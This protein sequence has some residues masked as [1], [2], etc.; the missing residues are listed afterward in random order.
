MLFE[1]SF[2]EIYEA[3]S[4]INEKRGKSR[5][6][7]LPQSSAESPT[8][9]RTTSLSGNF[10]FS[11]KRTGYGLTN[12]AFEDSINVVVNAL[13][14]VNGIT[15]EIDV[16]GREERSRITTWRRKLESI[17]RVEKALSGALNEKLSELAELLEKG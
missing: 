10:E 11:G 9:T 17:K 15:E 6:R 5:R 3:F 12:L 1:I 4:K 13:L 16:S 8:G 7:R 14:L 2:L